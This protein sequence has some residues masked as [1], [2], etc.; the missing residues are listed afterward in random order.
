MNGVPV[1]EAGIWEVTVEGEIL[2]L[3][4]ERAIWWPRRKVLLIAD[5]HLGK[6]AHFRKAGLA[7][8]AEVDESTLRKLE[9]LLGRYLPA[10]VFFL[11]DLFHS[12]YNATWPALGK[13]TGK[14]SQCRFHLVRGN[15][16]I[17]S[18][19]SYERSGIAVWEGGVEESPF[20][21]AH[22]PDEVIDSRGYVLAGHWHPGVRLRGRGRQSL[23]MPCFLLTR[24]RAILPA[25]GDF[26]GTK[27]VE[28]VKG[29]RVFAVAGG[30]VM[31]LP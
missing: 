30:K 1:E 14:W 18:G 22:D 11:G 29:D 15:H 9:D 21:L 2:W 12:E 24:N 6:A 26:T 27:V 10:E 13:L 25:F 7:V 8:P 20:T 17:L 19:V 16:D 23:R 28:P 3:L 4:P 31:P 5:L